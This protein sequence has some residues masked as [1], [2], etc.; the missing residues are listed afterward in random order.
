MTAHFKVKPIILDS[1][2]L[3]ETRK[4]YVCVPEKYASQNLPV[5]YLLDGGLKEHFP[6]IAE[7]ADR[8]IATKVISPFILVGIENI[9]RNYDFTNNTQVAKDKKWVPKYGN[10]KNFKKFISTELIPKI[11][12]EFNTNKKATVVGESL[13]GLLVLD[14][15][16]T[17]PNAFT[18]YI[19]I[20]PSLWWNN[21]EL[22]NQ[23]IVPFNFAL[24]ED[25]T[26][27]I[28]ASKTMAIAK[29][30]HE[31]AAILAQNERFKQNW[32]YQQDTEQNHFTIFK[33]SIEKALI[34]TFGVTT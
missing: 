25:K 13:G 7:M 15:F 23:C 5:M 31:M 12:A 16:F 28:S 32:F 27:W 21:Q 22:F 34:W 9:N 17:E 2:A 14:L 3:N 19:A 10:A 29:I 33:A 18:H 30:T 1:A 24:L 8:L 11:N 4:V 26:L 20:D 6:F